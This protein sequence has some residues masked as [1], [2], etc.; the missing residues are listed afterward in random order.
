M[1]KLME[2]AKKVADRVEIYS[3]S[4]ASDGVSFENARLKDIES[5]LQSGTGLLLIKDGRLGYA[6]TRNLIDREGLVRNALASIKGGVEAGYD[7][8]LTKDLPELATY[9]AG[10]ENLTSTKMVDECERICGEFAGKTEGQLNVSA[11]RDAWTVRVIN[12]SGTDL[13][14]RFS[15]YYAYTALYYP[16]SYSS[17][18]RVTLGKK[19]VPA[20]PEDL[21]YILGTYNGSLKEV[22]PATGRTRVLF[23]PETIYA[24]IWR[25][26]AATQGKSVYEQVSPLKDKLGEKIVSDRLTVL[27]RPLDDTWPGARAFDDE[28]TACRDVPIVE[29]GVLRNF[30]YDRYYA[31]KMNAESTGH[32]FRPGIVS[33][34]TPSLEHTVIKPGTESFADLLK[35]MGKG[36]IAAGVMGAHSGNILNGDFSIGLS[37]GLYVEDGEIV[38]QV[39]DAMVAGNIYDTLQNVIGVGDRLYPA[40]MGKFPAVLLDDVSFAAK[41]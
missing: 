4:G 28:G 9:D 24:L 38:G 16:G 20:S 7:L 40:S 1:E 22:K 25:L 18:S 41:G 11:G 27:D 39:K 35:K 19:F 14:S 30:Y 3:E 31:W 6:Y 13:S 23:L 32:G 2:I 8:P 34:V 21:D 15:S 5:S 36:I 37:P 12:S 10:I 26:K 29:D 33:R 17:V